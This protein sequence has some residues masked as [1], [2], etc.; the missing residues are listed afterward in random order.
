M[1]VT[2]VSAAAEPSGAWV[3][4]L[5]LGRGGLAA[6]KDISLCVSLGVS[7]DSEDP[8]RSVNAEP[9]GYV[10]HDEP[11]EAKEARIMSECRCCIPLI[12]SL[13]HLMCSATLDRRSGTDAGCATR[14]HLEPG[15]P[16]PDGCGRHHGYR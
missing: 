15:L 16:E 8:T 10:V 2:A 3:C 7:N 14:P 4:A 9:H 11:T 6:L 5:G 12:R 1:E 13:T